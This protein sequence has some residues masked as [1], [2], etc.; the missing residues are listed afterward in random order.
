MTTRSATEGF[1]EIEG[2]RLER[3][4]GGLTCLRVATEVCRAELYLHGAQ[5]CGWQPR[6]ES[7]PVLWM[8][9]RSQFAPGKAIRGGVPICFPWF[10]PNAARPDAP[11]HGFARTQEWRLVDVMREEDGTVMTRLS[12][13]ANDVSRA[14]GV[15]E[16]S[17]E[18]IARF[19]ATLDLALVVS[20]TGSSRFRFE[21]ALHTY[22]AVS[23]AGHVTVSG[24]AGAEYYDKT[25]GMRRKRQEGEISIAGETDRL[26]VDTDTP[27]VLHDPGWQRRIVISKTGSRSSVVW[28]PWV[29]RSAAMSDFGNEG[30]TGMTCIETVNAADNVVDLAPGSRHTMTARI[31]VEAS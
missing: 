26:Y 12:L 5:V 24:L 22:L 14:L 23:N 27:V 1:G 21:E 17:L 6:N 29:A 25:D 9:G 4:G 30:W 7:R 15:D 13:G 28:N 20:N 11:A 8:S 3:G 31:A 19:G 16:F 2:V 18:Y 10:G